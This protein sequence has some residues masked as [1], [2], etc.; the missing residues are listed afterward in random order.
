MPSKSNLLDEY[1][2]PAELAAELNV[3]TKTLDRWRVDSSGPPI[4]KIGR[5]PYYSKTGV[6]IWLREREQRKSLGRAP[7][8]DRQIS[9]A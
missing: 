8:V 5:K 6:V 2:Q 3:C 1:L 4:T 9:T 7:S